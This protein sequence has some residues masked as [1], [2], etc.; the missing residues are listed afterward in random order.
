VLKQSND[1][2]GTQT[3][4]P[5]TSFPNFGMSDVL[6]EACNIGMDFWDELM[7]ELT[8][9]ETAFLL[10]ELNFGLIFGVQDTTSG[11]PKFGNLPC[12]TSAR[13]TRVTY[14]VTRFSSDS[15]L[16]LGLGLRH[17]SGMESLPH[18]SG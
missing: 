2:V 16:G 14:R 4:Y 13:S 9:R 12:E 3:K 6:S 5:S 10:G 7:L 15:W 11:M 1:K 18:D 8:I 17:P